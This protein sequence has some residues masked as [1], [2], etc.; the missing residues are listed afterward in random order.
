MHR[1]NT[2]TDMAVQAI[3]ATLCSALEAGQRTLWLVS[4]GSNIAAEVAV[5]Q[6]LQV[7]AAAALSGLT[8]LPMD[9][10]YGQPGHDDSNTEQLRRAGF[11]PGPAAWVDVLAR[12]LPLTETVAYYDELV[13]SALAEA[14]A[15]ISQFGLGSDGHVAGILPGSPACT[16]DP[17]T[18]AGYEWRDYTRLTLTAEALKRTTTGYVLAYGEQ[19]RTALERLQTNGESFADLPAKVLYDLPEVYV[20]TD[21]DI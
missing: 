10:R 14:S 18:V 15:V 8:I 20:Y 9:E 3:A 6:R 13:S 5:M 17:A 4:G 2:P 12:N 11:E 19:K 16:D 21:N 7:H 1:I